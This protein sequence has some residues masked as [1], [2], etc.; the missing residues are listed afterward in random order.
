MRIWTLVA[1]LGLSGC[2]STGTTL[3]GPAFAPEPAAEPEAQPAVNTAAPEKRK[4]RK[5]N[6]IT[7]QAVGQSELD[8]ALQRLVD[9]LELAVT[10]LP[11]GRVRGR[12]ASGPGGTHVVQEGEYLDLIIE[13]TIPGSPIRKDLLRKAFVKL[14][15]SAFGGRGNPNYIFARKKLK[16]PS[17]EDLKAVIFNAGELEQ[18][19]SN[20][21]DPHQGWIQYP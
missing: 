10:R 2:S 18:L 1:I 9:D 14:N 4:P 13:K 11:S 17:V 15:P 16:V 21:A 7:G 20:S 8:R 3:F 5:V 6:P 19:R 12:D